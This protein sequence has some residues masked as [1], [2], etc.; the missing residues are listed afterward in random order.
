MKQSQ[1]TEEDEITIDVAAL[2]RQLVRHIPL[3]IAAAVVCGLF[4]WGYTTL[5]VPKQ[6]T[7]TTSMYVRNNSN[8][9]DAVDQAD[10]AASKSLT[11]TYIVILQNTTV[12]RQVSEK[13][14]SQYET[15]KI[16][17]AL[18][19]EDAVDALKKCVSMAADGDTEV[20][21]ISACTRDPEIS[22]AICDS[23]VSVAPD[24]LVRI[25]GAGTVEAI[26]AAEIPAAPSSPNV[27]KSTGIG[28]AVGL[29]LAVC[30]VLARVFLDRSIK[31]ETDLQQFPFPFLGEIPLN[32]TKK[33]T[34]RWP[35]KR[36]VPPE[37]PSAQIALTAALPFYI[38]E[39][40][41]AMRTSLTYA[42]ATK[43][44]A[45]I[46]V[47]SANASE[48]KSTVLANLACVQAMTEKKV[49][50]I[51]A[52]LR[53]PVQHRYMQL[54]NR[55]GL[56][57]VLAKVASVSEAVHKN[58]AKNMDVLTA[59]ACPPNPSELLASSAMQE[60]LRNAEKQ[61]DYVFVDTPP[62]NVV[63]DCLG[64]SELLGGFIFVVHCGTTSR[65]DAAAALQ[66]ISMTNASVLGIVLNGTE[67]LRSGYGK[68]H[69]YGAY[70]QKYAAYAVPQES[71]HI[72]QQ[73]A[74]EK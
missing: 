26:G 64:L 14:A 65:E 55:I 4:A 37:D 7:A 59:G 41:R 52:D 20:L 73:E 43:E 2:L 33:Q 21:N 15:E 72:E 60:L 69:K 17:A 34:H 3:L 13:L 42:I 46:A 70:A 49:L 71:E 16:S 51:D 56:S 58:V 40:Y 35:H 48:G 27:I 6:Y 50:L 12:I 44:H 23:Y 67:S 24:F 39:S 36:K 19:G 38:S 54:E 45:V 25:I 9:L 22:A 31:S 10:L 62:V 1:T 32:T 74:A 30:V 28:A 66:S 11:N 61:Y 18:G 68:Y 47:T 63:S 5:F 29:F 8:A 53:K 57:E